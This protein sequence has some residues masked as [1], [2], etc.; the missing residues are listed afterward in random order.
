MPLTFEDVCYTYGSADDKDA[1]LALDHVSFEIPDGQF[2]GVIGHTGSG[3][4]TLIQHMNGLLQPSSGRVLV[5]G[6]DLAARSSRHKVRRQVG[7][8]FQYPE[9]QLFASTVEED[10]AFGPVN[11][12]LPA[13]EVARRVHAAIERV[14]LDYDDVAKRSPFHLS[15]GQQRRAALAGILAMEPQVLVL[16]EP[17]AGLDPHGRD[18]ILGMVRSLHE[19]GLTIVMVS[20]SMEDVA[21]NAGRVLVMD[22]GK[23]LMDGSPEQ[24]FSQGEDLY[25]IGLDVPQ[26]IR[27]ER[28]LAAAG[29]DLEGDLHTLDALA[30]AIVARVGRRTKEQYL[31]GPACSDQAAVDATGAVR[32]QMAV[33]ATGAAQGQEAANTTGAAQGQAAEE[34]AR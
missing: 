19:D 30:D 26:A 10:V 23:L 20:H 12:G 32:G 15:G 6:L 22:H 8:A 31:A 17:M 1:R 13:D 28:K 5:N 4:S 9:Y 3:K 25:R 29:L 16:D 2:V 11:L 34:G 18:A 7:I 21:E 27:F 24:V 33:D 14:G